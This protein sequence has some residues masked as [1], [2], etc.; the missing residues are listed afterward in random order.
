MLA[1]GDWLQFAAVCTYRL[2]VFEEV[3][4]QP[5]RKVGKGQL[6]RC[7]LRKYCCQC[8][9]TSVEMS[10]VLHTDVILNI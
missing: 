7:N 1:G 2:G 4:V 3:T 10:T 8:V 6:G 5:H 9:I